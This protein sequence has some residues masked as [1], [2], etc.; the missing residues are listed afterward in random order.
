MSDLLGNPDLPP[1][2]K[3]RQR[4]IDEAQLVIG[5]GLSTAGWAA[6]VGLYHIVANPE[7]L[8]RARADIFEQVPPGQKRRDCTDLDWGALESLP[9][10][11]ACIREALRLS[12]GMSARTARVTPKDIIYTESVAA[13]EKTDK[14]NTVVRSWQIP[15]NTPV[16]MSIP[17]INHNEDI[18]PDS[19][20][21]KPERWLG[22]NKVPEK[23]FV[24]FSKGSRIC[25]GMQLA[26]A[27][28]SLMLAGVVRWFDLDLYETDESAVRMGSDAGV[29]IPAHN[30][31]LR[32]KVRAELD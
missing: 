14:G 5:A 9:Y 17:L 8:R 4:L 1:S 15:A 11:Q 24:S 10:F 7:V 29:P 3:T 26:W 21:F 22:P 23:Y 6:T 32:A 25:M 31:G 28:L 20:K 18:F 27:E 19:Y 2:M 30:N 16:S 12:Y 13:N